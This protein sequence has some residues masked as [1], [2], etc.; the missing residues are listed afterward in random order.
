ME[1]IPL[2]RPEHAITLPRRLRRRWCKSVMGSEHHDVCTSP[3]LSF[4][5]QMQMLRVNS[6]S[7]IRG[8]SSTAMHRMNT[9]LRGL[10][11]KFGHADQSLTG[12]RASKGRWPN[13]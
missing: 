13:R 9:A 1:L 10:S 2:V 4:K 3:R 8:A 11:L 5:S 6:H 12:I 7:L